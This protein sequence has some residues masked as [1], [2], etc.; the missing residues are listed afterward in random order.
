MR[1]SIELTKEAGL[2]IDRSIAWYGM[3]EE[4]VDRFLKAFDEQISLITHSPTL[5]PPTYEHK[6]VII[7]SAPLKKFPFVILYQLNEVQQHI[8]V[9][10]VWHTAQ[11]P[12]RWQQRVY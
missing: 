6:E 10:A 12:T 7:R 11:D 8:T 3:Q 9:F 1:C 2:D 4:I 5:Y